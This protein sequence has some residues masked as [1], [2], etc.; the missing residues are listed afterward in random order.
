[1]DIRGKGVNFHNVVNIMTNATDDN[2]IV[3]T[4]AKPL[5]VNGYGF[6]GRIVGQSSRGNGV[7]RSWSGRRGPWA[8][9]HSYRDAMRAVLTEYPHATIKT[10]LATYKGLDGFEQTYPGTAA[11]M[12]D[13]CDCHDFE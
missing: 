6:R 12:P 8:C 13:L 3:H 7:K 2:I 1:M 4:D 10:G 11:Y 5:G 9:W